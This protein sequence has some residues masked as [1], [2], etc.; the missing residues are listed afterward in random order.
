MCGVHSKDSES[1]YSDC[2]SIAF[3]FSKL[4]STLQTQQL[5]FT[6]WISSIATSKRG[7]TSSA[8]GQKTKSR[9]NSQVLRLLHSHLYVNA[10]LLIMT[11]TDFGISRAIGDVDAGAREGTPQVSSSSLSS[12]LFC[13]D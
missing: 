12:P 9:S 10:Y 2:F 3:F 4:H 11:S 13:S 1:I 7:T 6:H 8:N 5:T